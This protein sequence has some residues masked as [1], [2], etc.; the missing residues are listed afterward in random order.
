MPPVS[1]IAENEDYNGEP[2]IYG[3]AM[4]ACL[5]LEAPREECLRRIE[6]RKIDPQTGNIYHL[7][8]NP[9]PEDN[10]LKDRL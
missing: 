7:E 10:K 8:D 1:S 5:I 3:S 2:F 6:N 9:P 4:D